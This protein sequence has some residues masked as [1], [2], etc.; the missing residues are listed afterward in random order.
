MCPRR[1]PARPMIYAKI[2][3]VRASK[4][5]LITAGIT[6]KKYAKGEDYFAY[7]A[8]FPFFN[9]QNRFFP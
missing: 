6:E 9:M 8:R 5:F 7:F 4:N 1:I 2:K 3:K